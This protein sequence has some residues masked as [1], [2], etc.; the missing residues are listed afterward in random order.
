MERFRNAVEMQQ[1]TDSEHRIRLEKELKHTQQQFTEAEDRLRRAGPR[2]LPAPDTS[3]HRWFDDPFL[4]TSERHRLT[5]NPPIPAPPPVVPLAN[6]VTPW[7]RWNLLNYIRT[8]FGGHVERDGSFEFRRRPDTPP[9]PVRQ[10]NRTAPGNAPDD[11]SPFSVLGSPPVLRGS[12]LS[13]ADDDVDMDQDHI[14]DDQDQDF[15]RPAQQGR[16]RW[17]PPRSL[18]PSTV[19]RGITTMTASIGFLTTVPPVDEPEATTH[20]QP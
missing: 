17:D 7:V 15:E 9:T 5:R 14:V 18:L 13:P 8:P 1:K 2:P 3:P 4:P 16:P 11:P 12:N 6:P 10:G 20:P 19:H